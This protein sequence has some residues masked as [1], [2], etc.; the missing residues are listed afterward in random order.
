MALKWDD[1]TILNDDGEQVQGKAPVIISAS[2]S[3]DIPA[4]YSEW[5]I[6]RL[7]KG[8]IAWYNPFNAS[9]PYYVSFEKAKLFVFWT[10]DP[11][12]LMVY[13]EE[14]DNRGIGYYFQYT[15]NNYEKEGL[16]PDVEP[17][18]DRIE[19]FKELSNRIGK[20]KVI[21]RFDPLIVSDQL[22]PRELL[23]RIWYI[24][25]QLM[26]YTDKLVFSFVD[27]KAYRKVQNNLVRE[28]EFYNR[29][30]VEK[31]ELNQQQITEVVEGLSKIKAAWK[32]KGWD[33]KM[34]TCSETVD[35]D[36]YGIEH[37]RCVDDE[38]IRV[39][40]SK[41]RELMYFLDHGE[42]PNINKRNKKRPKSIKDTGQRM[43]CGCMFSKDIGRYNTCMHHCVYCYANTSRKMV[44]NNYSLH[45]PHYESITPAPK[46]KDES[47][48][49]VEK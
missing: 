38:L 31:A 4:F 49:K 17:L 41:D 36:K 48:E 27:V 28:T 3:T 19:T 13:L 11:K 44:E 21:W 22:P 10:K 14:F 43:V 20:E 45:D 42:L 23:K 32:E 16:E 9:K 1:I 2:R 30:S 15:L 33:V 5:L 8:Y 7:K 6:N 18:K 40:F 25:N 39:L 29:E 12:P 26:G 34:A 24:G 47:K 46:P 35:L 37:N